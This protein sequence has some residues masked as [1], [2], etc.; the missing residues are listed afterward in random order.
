M[1]RL[2]A[3]GVRAAQLPPSVVVGGAWVALIASMTLLALLEDIATI[4]VSP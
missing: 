4:E 2:V 3:Q 1:R